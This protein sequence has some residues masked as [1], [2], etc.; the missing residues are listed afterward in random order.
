MQ[1]N[2]PVFRRSEE[3]HAGGT[4]AYGNQM[5]AG[6][7]GTYQGYGADPSTWGTGTPGV[8]GQPTQA[9]P[10]TGPMTID[11]VVQ[12]TAIS[13]GVVILAAIATWILTPD[14]TAT[15][16]SN[17]DLGSLF[18]ALTVGS[19]GAFGL[20]LVNSFKR[21]ISPALV[22]AF[23]LL[24]GVALGAF[25]KL[26]D[27]QFSTADSGNIV[28]QAVIG[29]FAAFAGT[30][31]AYKFFNIQVGQKFRVFTIAAMFGM[32]GLGLFELVLG[33]FGNSFGLFGFGA[34]GMLTAIAGLV[35]GIFM[36]ILDFDFVEQGVANG[37]PERE[38]WRAA[39]AMTVSLVWI[40]TNL[41]RL[42]A[43]FSDN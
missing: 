37:L 10:T 16:V 32:V 42:L 14:I 20:S 31:A 15:T 30:L 29:T 18:A 35:L 19:L 23:A 33:M 5:Y 40:Y 26:I 36:L 38:S 11:T 25:S 8:P 43:I 17:G 3:F 27:A 1:S 6:N 4:N 24:E 34:L 28:I 12:K 22:I 39:F 9:P 13:L 7:G 2:N 21:V 41:L